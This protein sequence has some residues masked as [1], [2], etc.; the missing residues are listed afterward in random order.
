MREIEI[1]AR[2]R[3]VERFQASLSQHGI[4]VPAEVRQ[5]DSIYVSKEFTFAES[6]GKYKPILRLRE[7]SGAFR[8][9]LKRD[10]SDDLDS[11]EYETEVGNPTDVHAILDE[12]GYHFVLRISKTRRAFVLK[13]FKVCLDDVEGLG[14]FVE[15]ECL[16]KIGEDVVVIRNILWQMLSEL[17]ISRDDEVTLGYDRLLSVEQERKSNEAKTV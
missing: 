9:T 15:I 3:D 11:I 8:L 10:L 14:T 16:S 13:T 5:V 6:K 2:L 4:E 12:L 17:G 1:K 7:Q